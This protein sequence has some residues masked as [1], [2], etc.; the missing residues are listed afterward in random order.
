MDVDG[1]FLVSKS[2]LSAVGGFFKETSK[3]LWEKIHVDVSENGGTP[4]WMVSNG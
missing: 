2:T 3:I 1:N 4:K